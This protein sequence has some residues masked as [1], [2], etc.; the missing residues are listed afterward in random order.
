ME[1]AHIPHLRRDTKSGKYF[2]AIRY[3]TKVHR[4]PLRSKRGDVLRDIEELKRAIEDLR[5]QEVIKFAEGCLM[6]KDQTYPYLI[7]V[8]NR[9]KEVVAQTSV[10]EED[11]ERT[12]VRMWHL[13]T[14]G[15]VSGTLNNAIIKMHHYILGKPP[16]GY[17]VDHL[18][19]N[20]LNN[21][22]NNL[23]YATYSQN[24]QNADRKKRNN[25]IGSYS[26]NG[27]K[28][29]SKSS[30]VILG[31]FNTEE[32]AA[33]VYD[34]YTYQRLGEQSRTN[35]LISYE[36]AMSVK[37]SIPSL[38][39]KKPRNLPEHIYHVGKK[40]VCI[41]TYNKV[42]RRSPV[43]G[44][45][46]EAQEELAKIQADVDS[47]IRENTESK[48]MQSITHDIAIRSIRTR[49]GAD[50][51][52]DADM[53]YELSQYKWHITQGYG[54]G[55][56]NGRPIF[57]H[58]YIM[59][60]KTGEEIPKGLVV[61]HINNEKLDNRTGNL[62]IVNHSIN[63]HNR[64]KKAGCI[65][66]YIGI[67]VTGKRYQAYIRGNG[68]SYRIGTFDTEIEAAIAYNNE[69]I[70]IHGLENAKLNFIEEYQWML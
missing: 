53:W 41:I 40:F 21:T 20:R 22:R 70:E 9:R 44:T 61:D 69:A 12:K 7:N 1:N 25:Y 23:R 28:Y 27:G 16:P 32:E 10:S 47:L 15:Y 37:L 3:R 59:V 62:R 24:S 13:R 6:Y 26:A 38:K 2:A 8:T 17:V 43:V 35:G 39:P 54:S 60:L 68:K 42:A 55:W 57:M 66:K 31:L 67:R 46:E 11:F 65:S 51:L 63:S 49:S 18:D 5:T 19:G 30:G 14:D 48:I 36:D 33:R 58:R 50:I 4:K 52:V 34:I 64:Q 45:V 56:I 29:T